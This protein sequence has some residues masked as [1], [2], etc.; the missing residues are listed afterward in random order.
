MTN[1][2]KKNIQPRIPV[3]EPLSLADLSALLVKH[4]GLTT[5]KY[6]L[7]V[8]FRIGMGNIGPSEQE[9]LP[10]AM[11]G[12]HRVGL[13]QVEEDGPFTVDASTL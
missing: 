4:Y 7:M 1:K 13:V 10:G 6:E 9:K 12:V 11:V 2:K 8:E 3:E 5:G